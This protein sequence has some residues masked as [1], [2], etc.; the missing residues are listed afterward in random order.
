MTLASHNHPDRKTIRA[1][2]Y[3]WIAGTEMQ[4]S[5][6]GLL[7]ELLF[8][9][10]RQCPE[11]I[12]LA[13][14]HR[15]SSD[16]WDT[17]TPWATQE[18]QGVLATLASGSCSSVTFTIFIDGLDEY[19]GDHEA[20]CT[21][22]KTL[23]DSPYIKLCV[24][25]RPWNV[26]EEAF[27]Q[28]E[29]SKLYMQDLTKHDIKD[30]T[31]SRLEEHPRWQAVASRPGQGVELVQEIVDKA[32]GVF[33]W[34]YLVTELLR[35]GLT[36]RDSFSD[37]RRR[38]ESFPP[39]LEDFFQRI[40]ESVEAFYHSKMS[41]ALQLAAAADEPLHWTFYA[42]HEQEYDDADYVFRVPNEAFSREELRE[43]RLDTATQLNSR[44]QG[45]L[46][47]TGTGLVTFLHRTVKDYLDTT[48]MSDFLAAKA[49][50]WFSANLT[51]IRAGIARIKRNLEVTDVVKVI[52][53]GF[54][55]YAASE[56][57][58]DI[59]RIFACAS[60]ME[61]LGPS[62]THTHDLLDELEDSILEKERKGQIT[63]DF[64]VSGMPT[65]AFLGEH[66]IT[67]QLVSYL[68]KKLS[69]NP[70]YLPNTADLTS[71]TLFETST[72][73]WH[74]TTPWRSRGPEMLG[75][76]LNS[77]PFNFGAEQGTDT[78]ACL[79]HRRFFAMAW[80]NVMEHVTTWDNSLSEVKFW[81]LLRHD[82][83]SLLISK[84]ASSIARSKKDGYTMI[85][86]DYLFL[87]FRIAP[88]PERESQ[89]LRTLDSFLFA[90]NNRLSAESTR[91]CKLD[92]STDTSPVC[93]E[94]FKKLTRLKIISPSQVSYSL[95]TEV[96]HQLLV[97]VR[98]SDKAERW[99]AALI[100]AAIE[101]GLPFKHRKS[102]EARHPEVM[103]GP[104][105]HGMRPADTSGATEGRPLR[106]A[107]VRSRRTFGSRR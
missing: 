97:M 60:A 2:H 81:D 15:V 38:L 87:C 100:R 17:E 49:A 95:I 46:E 98:D 19:D 85:W 18:L 93:E 54:G 84:G 39:E 21:A 53:G 6:Q 58:T 78:E 83:L 40:L 22:L 73:H 1:S 92:D 28:N 90:P 16:T 105:T 29:D 61:E 20:L 89:Y 68:R 3:F 26:F 52:R 101:E 51:L 32:C 82:I 65:T 103:Q 99:P 33:L 86:V 43:L 72:V 75:C 11:L 4:K 76:I 34:V 13:C 77:I 12:A 31:K 44:T 69:S 80:R 79:E 7:R 107:P 104:P 66:V 96:T 23:A 70:L 102:L 42:F 62:N 27:G 14:A 25:S 64:G 71:F 41:T 88:N 94:Y 56:F 30:Y 24:S 74:L 57:M 91:R 5:Q 35:K 37:M 106:R 67:H 50:P 63:F 55:K 48:Q 59:T 8:D 45:L 36:N 9:M 47:I 10:F